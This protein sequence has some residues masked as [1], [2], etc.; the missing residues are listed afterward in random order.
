[1]ELCIRLT[2]TT[3]FRWYQS[4][5][6][7]NMNHQFL[8]LWLKKACMPAIFVFGFTKYS[9]QKYRTRV[10]EQ[11]VWQEAFPSRSIVPQQTTLSHALQHYISYA[12]SFNFSYDPPYSQS[13]IYTFCHFHPSVWSWHYLTCCA[14]TFLPVLTSQLKN[15]CHSIFIFYR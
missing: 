5:L 10:Q 13:Q 1:M 3:V 7:T 6:V 9:N 14:D 15:T 8:N 12:N 2:E 4:L 11:I